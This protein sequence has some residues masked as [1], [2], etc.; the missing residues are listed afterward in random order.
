[1]PSAVR[2]LVRL[3]LHAAQRAF[4]AGAAV[5]MIAA[6]TGCAKTQE[7]DDVA[8]VRAQAEQGNAEAESDLGVHYEL[9]R[10]VGRNNTLAAYWYRKAAESGLSVAQNNLGRLYARGQG[11]PQDF[12]AA[13]ILFE[14]AASQGH[15]EAMDNLGRIYGE[16]NGVPTDKVEALK[17]MY[18]AAAEYQSRRISR[19][20][21]S[22][23]NFY[24]LR[25]SMSAAEVE[26]AKQR[27]DAWKPLPAWVADQFGLLRQLGIDPRADLVETVNYHWSWTSR[28]EV[29]AGAFHCP[30]GSLVDVSRS[31]VVIRAPSSQPCRG[32]DS[33][34]VDMLKVLSDGSAE[35]LSG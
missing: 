7:A 20:V 9:G 11:V 17:W 5:A 25:T 6:A 14:K 10:G 32:R 29:V 28:R 2:P 1:M 13:R 26:T 15:S 24:Q 35:P 18:L 30:S 23:A 8:R 27:A 22:T 34:A 33:H 4:A 16:G 21:Y 12:R 31:I 19:P 3:A